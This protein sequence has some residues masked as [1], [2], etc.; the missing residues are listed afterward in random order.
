MDGPRAQEIFVTADERGRGD[1]S[2]RSVGWLAQFHAMA[3]RS[4][5]VLDP[6]DELEAAERWSQ[7]IA[8]LAGPFPS[9]ARRLF[10]R[11][12]E[13]APSSSASERCAG[14]GRYNCNQI[15]L[16]KDQTITL[17]RAG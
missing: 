16:T 15:I 5:A 14:H 12:E 9:Q 8:G 11:L 1:A 13:E 2:E 17:D 6:I 3:P 10:R 4:G 7:T